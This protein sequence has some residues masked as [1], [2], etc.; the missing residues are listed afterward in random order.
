MEKHKH[1]PTREISEY[2][3]VHDMEILEII[4]KTLFNQMQTKITQTY[5]MNT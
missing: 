1:S 5:L 4:K 2:N 3:L